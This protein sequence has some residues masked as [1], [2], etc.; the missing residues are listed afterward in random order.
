MTENSRK[1]SDDYLDTLEQVKKQYQQYVEV[2]GLYELPMQK[3]DENIQY[4]PPSPE[5]PLTTN[6]IRLN[7]PYSRQGTS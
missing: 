3:E 4:Q 5:H 6:G 2:S 1:T 7:A